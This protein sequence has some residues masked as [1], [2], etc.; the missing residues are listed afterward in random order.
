[1]LYNLLLAFICLSITI[2][3][4]W[5]F[6]SKRQSIPCPSWLAWLV[7]LDN[8]FAKVHR[9]VTIVANANIKPGMKVLD[10]GCGPGRVTIPATTLLR[11][12]GHVTA[13]DIQQAMLDKV[14]T[15]AKAQQLN[16]ISYIHAGLGEGK[17]PPNNFDRA[18]LITVIGEIPDQVSALQEIYSSLKPGGMLSITEIIFDPHFHR[19]S[20]VTKLAN[21][22]GFIEQ[23]FYGNRFA[24]MINFIKQPVIPKDNN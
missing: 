15:K 11:E 9:A 19:R 1:M 17:L 20:T 18:L 2:T 12:R 22:V 23:A 5:R 7:E 14:N 3:I 16:N 6:A 21:E 24:Y 8:P 4:V 13:M 10:A